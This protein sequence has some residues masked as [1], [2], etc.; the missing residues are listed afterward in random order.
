MEEK[1]ITTEDLARMV[2]NGFGESKEQVDNLEKW[3]K[4]RFDN[5][6]RDLKLIHKQLT[7]VVYRHEFEELESRVKDLEGLLTVGP[8]KKS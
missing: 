5:I 2:Q 3:A 8:K 7:G 6:D 1:K 4:Q